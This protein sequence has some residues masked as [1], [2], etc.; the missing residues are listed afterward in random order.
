MLKSG[1]ENPKKIRKLCEIVGFTSDNIVDA[2]VEY[3]TYDNINLTKTTSSNFYR[4][5][6]KLMRLERLIRES[7]EP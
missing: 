3:Y 4:A 7:N 2:L 5:K 1:C 6:R